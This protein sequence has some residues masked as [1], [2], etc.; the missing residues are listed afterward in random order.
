M[1]KPKSYRRTDDLESWCLGVRMTVVAATSGVN[2]DN[3]INVDHSVAQEGPVRS[4]VQR[5]TTV[6]WKRATDI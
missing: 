6:E 3:F 2:K 4:I 5:L 1:L